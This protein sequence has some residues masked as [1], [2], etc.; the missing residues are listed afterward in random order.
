MVRRHRHKRQPKA[1]CPICAYAGRNLTRHVRN[2]HADH[3][4]KEAALEEI[5]LR[6][7]HKVIQTPRKG[8]M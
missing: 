2:K 6:G 8:V 1:R 7:K 5:R 3:P 4:W